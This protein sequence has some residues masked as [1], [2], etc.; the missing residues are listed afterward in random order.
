MGNVRYSFH[1]NPSNQLLERLQSDDYY[2]FGKRKSSGSPISL[3]NKY[4]YNGKEL[5][6]ELGQ[7]DYGARFYDPELGRWTTP[8][9]L[10][11]QYRRWSPYNYVMNNPLRF[12]D[13]DGMSVFT[14]SRVSDIQSLLDWA[15]VASVGELSYDQDDSRKK[16]DDRGLDYNAMFP[17]YIAGIDRTEYNYDSPE[18]RNPKQDKLLTPGEIKR[19][20]EAG[21]DH[22]D[23]GNGGGKIDLYKDKDGNVYEKGKGNKGPG[24]PIGV[25]LNDL[26]ST[27]VSTNSV[28]KAGTAI[29]VGI[30]IYEIIKWGGAILLAPET[31]GGSLAGA[32]VLP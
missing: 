11:E 10:A 25:N 2:A 27:G 5:Q 28:L 14:S 26:K 32:A 23:K 22:S 18:D 6:E 31:L 19:L 16:E 3:N 15:K 30:V 24:E 20:K 9:P 12:V 7:L 17:N 29:T 1:K 21:W 8:D 4:L 13:P